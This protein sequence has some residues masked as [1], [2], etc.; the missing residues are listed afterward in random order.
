MTLTVTITG[1]TG[2]VGQAL[3]DRLSQ[4]QRAGAAVHLQPVARRVAP[5]VQQVDDYARSPVGDVL[6][7]LAECNDRREVE[8]ASA[9]HEKQAASTLEA[10]LAMGF[11]RTIYASSAALYGDSSDHPHGA[12][13][14]VQA[15]DAYV[16]IKR[17]G[18]LAVL[19][20]SGGVVARLVNLYGP[21]MPASNVLSRIL[22]QVPGQGP[23]AVM[24][25]APVR[26]FLWIDDAADA[27]ARMIVGEACGA[28]NVGTGA[29]TSVGDLIRT[30]LAIAGQPDRDILATAPSSRRSH[31]VVDPTATRL[32]FGWQPTMTLRDGLA[33][34]LKRPLHPH[35]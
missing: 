7:H 1:A 33:A 9:L 13:D 35:A 31:L 2:F 25:L 3:L 15:S 21:G 19:R 18:E 30:A 26:D 23:V 27:L 4:L 17:A 22:Q 29:G 34:L 32:A 5:G 10:L 28:F 16:R 12:D 20:R 6:V 14:P 11:R 8:S 24:D